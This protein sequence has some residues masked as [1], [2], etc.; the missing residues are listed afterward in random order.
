MNTRVRIAPSPT[1]KPHIGTIYIALFNYAF[2]KKNNGS[3]I[4]RIE[5]TD[6]KRSTIKSEREIKKYLK[7]FDFKYNE[8]FKIGNFGPYKQSNRLHI[9][10]MFIKRSIE[11]KTSYFCF[12]S[13][14]KNAKLKEYYKNSIKSYKYNYFCRFK[15]YNEKI[16]KKN[17]PV[18]RM[19]SIFLSDITFIDNLRGFIFINGKDI[20]DQI[21]FKSD[22]FPTYHFANIIDDFLM[23]ISHVIRGEEWMSSTP[24]HV[25]LY[26]IYFFKKPLYFHLPLL[27][28]FDKSKISKRKNQITLE[29][30]KDSG[31]LPSAILNFLSLI[32]YDSSK[33]EFDLSSFFNNFDI[34]KISLGSPVFD[35]KKLLW[36]NKNYIKRN[37]SKKIFSHFKFFFLSNKKIFLL[38]NS[39]KDRISKFEDFFSYTH[40]FFGN[41]SYEEE[42]LKKIKA[43]DIANISFFLDLLTEYN[44]KF[45]IKNIEILS[46]N[47]VAVKELNASLFFPILRF[48]LTGRKVTPPLFDVI[49]ILGRSECISRIKN[50]LAEIKDLLRA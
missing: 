15:K 46:R 27:R 14:N 22:G 30:F 31:F 33:K 49:Y 1:G 32:S 7:W 34:Y 13:L 6:L 23:K 17:I 21:I 50:F 44:G 5:D 26:K 47:F 29:Y 4:V 28:N 8:G 12:C 36:V 42:Y 16:F 38:F 39:F 25:L 45:I 24:K 2:A 48:T 41:V 35:E 10:K 43:C 20:D 40:Y 3:F 11:N 9:Y 18:I 19:K 37:D